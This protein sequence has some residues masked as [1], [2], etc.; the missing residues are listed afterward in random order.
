MDRNRWYVLPPFQIIVRLTFL[1]VSLTTYL[2]QKICQ[3]LPNLSYSWRSCIDKATHNKR[4]DILHK[5]L[6]KTSG[7]LRV[8]KVKR[9]IIWNEGSTCSTTWNLTYDTP[10]IHTQLVFLHGLHSEFSSCVASWAPTS[11]TS[12]S[13]ASAARLTR[14]PCWNWRQSSMLSSW[15]G[16]TKLCHGPGLVIVCS[17]R[18]V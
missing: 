4:S 3:T 12:F 5:F 8:K 1:T 15:N 18:H 17:H 11:S 6:N 9:P 2:I 16:I 14:M 7:Q 10:C 13:Q